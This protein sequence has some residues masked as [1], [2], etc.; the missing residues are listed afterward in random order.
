MAMQVPQSAYVSIVMLDKA[1]RSSGHN[2]CHR[3][4]T[5]RR[6]SGKWFRGH[7]ASAQP[8]SNLKTFSMQN[9]TRHLS[10]LWSGLLCNLPKL[11]WKKECKGVKSEKG[12]AFIPSLLIFTD[13]RF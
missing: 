1:V 4:S 6:Q 5:W 11:D 12:V 13:S 10:R 3:P 2:S 9:E 8:I 7:F